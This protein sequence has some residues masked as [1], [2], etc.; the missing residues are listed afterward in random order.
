MDEATR[1]R[2][3]P[4][5]GTT[6]GAKDNVAVAGYPMT[7][8]C[9]YR[10]GGAPVP[11]ESA[12]AVKRLMEKG[13]VLIG[14]TNMDCAATGLVGVRSAYGACQNSIDRKYVSG[15]SSSGSGVVVATGQV[16]FALGTDTAGSGRVPAMFNNIVGLKASR[17][18]VSCHGV[19]PACRTLDCLTVF[20]LTVREAEAVVEAAVGAEGTDDSFDR[21]PRDVQTGPR[22]PPTGPAKFTFGIPGKAHLDFESFGDVGPRAASFASAWQRSVEALQAA[23]GTCVEVDY[24]PFWEA[25]K[26]LYGGPWVAERASA[27]RELLKSKPEAVHPTVRKIVEPADKLGAIEAFE[28]AYKLRDWKA[29]AMAAMTNAG[30]QVL[31]TPTAGMIYTIEEVQADPI[32]L[33][34]NLGR[35]T[36][37]MNLLDLCGIAVPTVTAD[38]GL[39]FGVT[40]SAPAGQDAFVCDI[41]HLVHMASGLRAGA[42]PSS[43]ADVQKASDAVGRVG[44][45]LL[46]GVEGIEVAVSG[47]H[48][49]GLPLSWQLTERGGRFLR[50]AKTAP[51]YRLLAFTGMK[52]PRP[53][54]GAARHCEGAAVDLEIWELPAATF[55]SFMKVIAAP[56]GIGWL[57]LDDGSKV[58]GFRLID[59]EADCAGSVGGEPP[60]DI[61]SHG[62][63]RS[64]LQSRDPVEPPAKRAKA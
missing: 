12:A 15:G 34:T 56:L 11:T 20:A 6:F 14:K 28:A 40:I 58:Q 35:Y 46:A 63:W 59:T 38:G 31:V 8:G 53:G 23:G 32:A 24:E 21:A 9:D 25:A 60:V 43:A 19:E 52:P 45:A 16:T 27:L 42:L 5:L 17:G 33:N 37:H 22:L 1:R 47:A 39:P 13:A 54:L 4:L 30:A 61:T 62:G 55:G 57:Q 36:N 41:A 64:Y 3:L 7:N 48:M 44:G 51:C 49:R 10:S 26:L 50:C 2:E 18:F 29:K